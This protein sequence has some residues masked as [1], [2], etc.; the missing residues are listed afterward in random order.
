MY[1]ITDEARKQLLSHLAQ[2]PYYI[3]QPLLAFV[4]ANVK[5]VEETPEEK[6]EEV[7]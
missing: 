2:L 5:P 1:Q 7:V 4:E 3:A 6:T